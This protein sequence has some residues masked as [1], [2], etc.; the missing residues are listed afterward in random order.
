MT[1]LLGALTR[2]H[3]VVAADGLC[4]KTDPQ[5]GRWYVRDLQ[6]IF[7]FD[8]LPVAIA[9]HGQNIICGRDIAQI[10]RDFQMELDN[11]LRFMSAKDI[12]GAL[13]SHLGDDPERELKTQPANGPTCV[14]GFWIARN[15]PGI[16]PSLYELIWKPTPHIE[17]LGACPDFVWGGDGQTIAEEICNSDQRTYRL[18][19]SI[20]NSRRLVQRLYEEA[21]Q[22]EERR[23]EQSNSEP[24]F[25]GHYHQLTVAH[26]G[27]A[28]DVPPAA[29]PMS[30]SP[31]GAQ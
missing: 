8:G 28:W 17:P 21:V 19:A 23:A 26:D 12:A 24:G 10:A 6:K 31:N 14:I 20:S 9:H 15:A 5:K 27:C 11:D 3:L 30:S 25:G 2:S 13:K 18:T 1:L 16:G 29:A 7:P 4:V 22:E